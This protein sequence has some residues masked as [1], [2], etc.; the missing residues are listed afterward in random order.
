MHKDAIDLKYA[1]KV[2]DHI[3][4]DHTEVIIN[5][6]DVLD[7]LEEVVY[8]LGTYDITTIRASI[9]M[10]LV[11]KWIHENT[12]IRVILTGEISDEIFGYKYTDFAPDAAAFQA[13][14][15]KRIREIHMYDVLRADRCI[16]VHSL[17]ARVP[18]GDLDFLSY[19]MSIDPE[20]KLNRYGIGKYLLRH[21][22]EQD[23][24]IPREIL[25]RE[26]AAFSDAVGHSLRLDIIDYAQSLY[27][28]E[29][30][31]T[32]RRRYR[33]GM[34]FTK[35]SLLFREIF[36]K[37]YPGQ[38]EMI[39]DFWMPNRDWEGCDVNDPSASVL[40]NYGASGV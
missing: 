3:G 21:A 17:E 4:S 1:K 40:S 32:K 35:E 37:Y 14:S 29:E 34:P 5:R 24:L 28:D 19:C 10:Y 38:A 9:G 27:T 39:T 11:C 15:E 33:H 22:F 2:A 12:D 6:Q 7:A 13:E 23:G 18:F 31:E 20:M 8:L 30:Y 36:E 25:M 26:K 16:S